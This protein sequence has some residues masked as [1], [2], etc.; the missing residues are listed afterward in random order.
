MASKDSKLN[1][2]KNAKM[3]FKAVCRS[4][5]FCAAECPG[6]LALNTVMSL[7]NVLSPYAVLVLWRYILDALSRGGDSLWWCVGLYITVQ[8]IC[9]L[10]SVLQI[11]YQQSSRTRIDQ[12]MK[13]K[14]IDKLREVEVGMYDDP[15]FHRLFSVLNRIPDYSLLVD[16]FL[17]VSTALLS[18]IITIA[19][20]VS[21]YLTAALVILI[22]QIPT[23]I[24]LSYNAINAYKL[25]AEEN[26]DRRRIGYYRDVMTNSAYAKEIRL[27]DLGAIFFGL[28]NQYWTK[29]YR[30]AMKLQKKGAILKFL[31]SI[32][33]MIGFAFL[34]ITLIG[35][36]AS[37]V[38]T[39]GDL[40]Y[41][42]GLGVVLM[43]NTEGFGIFYSQIYNDSKQCGEIL[44]EYLAIRPGMKQGTRILAGTPEIEFRDV[45]F[46][47]PGSEEFVLKHISFKLNAGE[48]LLLAGINGSGKTTLVKLILRMYDP[49]EG[50]I[51]YNGIPAYEY[52]LH[53][54]RA[55][56]GVSF[57]NTELYAKSFRKNV[58]ISR[59]SSDMSD[60]EI[61]EKSLEMSGADKVRGK[62]SNADDTE[63]TRSFDEKGYEPSGGEKQRIGLA[64]AYYRTADFVILDEPSSAQDAISEDHIFSQFVSSYSG[65]GAVL[66]SHRMSAA[67]IVDKI[68]L[69]ENGSMLAFGTHAEIY[70][71]NERYCQIYG[72]QASGYNK[73]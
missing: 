30:S 39:A 20:L 17:R 19:A 18:L 33:G 41:Y 70:A 31:G 24:I 34:I 66:I 1:I 23:V 53:S 14:I 42:V 46:K 62:L 11:A 35:K 12:L 26:D 56:F 68:A 6:Y 64:R 71:S 49:T 9:Q 27:Y 44:D 55:C 50:L 10:L 32:V 47:Y 48:K 21:G 69:I 5:S 58:G 4:L 36:A 3:I 28:Y 72:M 43:S 38:L 54:L 40:Y 51:L 57:Q 22:F 8:F 67:S 61:Y 52:D 60:S 13:G 7:V 73:V 63:L 37:G 65:K 25:W 16:D 2:A 59:L 15:D 45:S 29:L